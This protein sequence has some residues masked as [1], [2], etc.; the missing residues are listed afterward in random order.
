VRCGDHAK[1]IPGG[2]DR[3]KEKMPGEWQRRANSILV[4]LLL[5]GGRGSIEQSYRSQFL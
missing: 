4:V 2:L 1:K 5:L 3:S